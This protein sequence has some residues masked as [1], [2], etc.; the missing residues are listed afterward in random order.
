MQ[1]TNLRPPQHGSLL[2]IFLTVF[3]DLLGFGIVLPLLPIY[4][5]QFAVQHGLTTA[6]AGW[7]VGLL[8]ASFSA[9]QFLFLPVW[10]ACPTC[11]DVVRFCSW[12]WRVP[13]CSTRCSGGHGLG[14]PGLVVRGA[15]RRG[16]R[17][18]DDFDRPGVHCGYHVGGQSY[19]RHGADRRGLCAW[20]SRWGR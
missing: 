7:V 20:V 5:E 8:M 12:A 18:G 15:D 1:S 9:M 2:V 19:E 16:H 10:G 14:Q 17:R 4:G 11:T 3:I 6:Q 13:L